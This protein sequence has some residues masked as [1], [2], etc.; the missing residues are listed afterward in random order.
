MVYKGTL[1]RSQERTV[2]LLRKINQDDNLHGCRELH[3]KP[4]LI[5]S[6]SL[7]TCSRFHEIFTHLTEWFAKYESK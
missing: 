1:G 4:S 2:A 7:K 6:L 5:S 3:K